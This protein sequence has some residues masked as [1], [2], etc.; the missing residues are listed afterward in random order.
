M[1]VVGRVG[2]VCNNWCDMFVEIVIVIQG[3]EL[4]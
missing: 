4:G 1:D 2:N 3:K